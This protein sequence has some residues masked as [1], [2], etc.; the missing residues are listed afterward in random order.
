MIF[1]GFFP[2]EL[3]F[4]LPV[5]ILMRYGNQWCYGGCGVSMLVRHT[6][7]AGESA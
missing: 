3:P 1:Y 4:K 6:H 7:P 5:G 2:F